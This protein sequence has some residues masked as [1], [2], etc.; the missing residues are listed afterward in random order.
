MPDIL[1]ESKDHI[2]TVTL[3]RPD[4]LNAISGEMLNRL[5]EVLLECDHDPDVRVLF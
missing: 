5:S 1:L 4:R 3:N 2:A